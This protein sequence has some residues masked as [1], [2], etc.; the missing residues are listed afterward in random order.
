MRIGSG[1]RSLAERES[2]IDRDSQI[3][4]TVGDIDGGDVPMKSNSSAR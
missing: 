4:I 2:E 1:S 3:A